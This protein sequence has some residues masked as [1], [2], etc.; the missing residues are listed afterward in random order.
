MKTINYKK[1]FYAQKSNAKIRG[2]EWELTFDEWL[3][4]WESS[5]HLI[6]RGRGI[7]KYVMSRIGDIGPYSFNNVFI[8]L[9]EKNREEVYSNPKKIEQMNEKKSQK[10]KGVSKS[11]FTAEH[12][13]NMRIAALR[14]HNPELLGT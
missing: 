7:G 10:T 2:I 13:N 9:W 11:P 3:S 5:G 8:Q 1:D 4:I 6:N 14:R 12:K